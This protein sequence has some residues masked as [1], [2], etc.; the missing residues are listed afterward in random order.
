MKQVVAVIP[1]RLESSRFPGKLLYPVKGRPLLYYGWRQ[2]TKAK[3]V[4]RTIIATDSR[5]IAEAATG[6]GAEVI[7][8]S[9]RPRTGT[10]RVAE[11]MAGI[12]ARIVINVQGDNV[13]LSPAAVDRVIEAM[14]ADRS[15]LYATLARPIKTDADLFDPSLSKV[16]VDADGHALWFSRF[17]L[18]FLQHSERGTRAG[19]FKFMGHI[20]VYFFRPKGLEQFAAWKRTPCEKAES[21]EQLRILENGGKMRVFRTTARTISVDTPADLKKIVGR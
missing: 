2:V 10:D 6:F 21:L 13:A 17:P 14:T 5:E 1:A 7:R 20:G 16:V 4:D 9:K 11:A 18:P 12:P 15:C 19:Q 3:R 8:T